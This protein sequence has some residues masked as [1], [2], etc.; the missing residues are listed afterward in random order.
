[1]D[2]PLRCIGGQ[3]HGECLDAHT[4]I[5]INAMQHNAS[6]IIDII[7]II[8]INAMQRNASTCIDHHRHHRNQCNDHHRNASN[9]IAMHANACERAS[10]DGAKRHDIAKRCDPGRS[11]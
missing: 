7:N 4:I 3:R 5:D 1:M 2:S 9:I 6:T 10:M 11:G 8:D